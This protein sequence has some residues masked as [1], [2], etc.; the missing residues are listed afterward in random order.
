MGHVF[1][2][3][4]SLPM[5]LNTMSFSQ[6]GCFHALLIP[7]SCPTVDSVAALLTQLCD[8]CWGITLERMKT[9]DIV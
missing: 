7:T 3:S 5:S 6:K 8:C 2:G 4:Y 1:S 9:I